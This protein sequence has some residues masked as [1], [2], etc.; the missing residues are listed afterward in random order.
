M[1]RPEPSGF[2]RS[3]GTVFRK[4]GEQCFVFI[5]MPK[6]II[7][8]QGTE[9]TLDYDLHRAA[10]EICLALHLVRCPQ[11]RDYQSHSDRR[12]LSAVHWRDTRLRS[13]LGLGLDEL[14]LSADELDGLP[15][16]VAR[17]DSWTVMPCF[18]AR[19]LADFASRWALEIQ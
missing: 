12:K 10:R 14:L 8:N 9:N 3:Q 5:V 17:S 19:D 13:E 2:F 6:I 16:A 15:S 4:D 11:R 7:M 1:R 18:W